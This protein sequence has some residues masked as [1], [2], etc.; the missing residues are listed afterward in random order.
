[1]PSRSAR[2]IGIETDDM[3]TPSPP[4]LFVPKIGTTWRVTGGVLVTEPIFQ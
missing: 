3:E 4:D 2:S 1:M